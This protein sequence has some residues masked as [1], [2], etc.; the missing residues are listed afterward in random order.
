MIAVHDAGGVLLPG[1]EAAA[2][3]SLGYSGEH[4]DAK[5][6]Q[7]YLRAR[8][9]DP[10]N[11]RFNRL[12]PFAGNMQDPQSLHK[13]A[14]VHGDPIMSVDP[15]GKYTAVFLALDF[16]SV[17]LEGVYAGYT[18]HNNGSDGLEGYK[19]GV[20][21]S[22]L[23]TVVLTTV[24][25]AYAPG[26][27]QI[28][29][30]LRVNSGFWARLFRS[31]EFRSR[32]FKIAGHRPARMTGAS[33]PGRGHIPP[34]VDLN[35]LDTQVRHR[36]NDL[37]VAPHEIHDRAF[38]ADI[39]WSSGGAAY[40]GKIEVDSGIFRDDLFDVLGKESSEAWRQL[41]VEERIDAV[42]IHESIE[43]R[44]VKQEA[45]SADA[46]L[47]PDE[48]QSSHLQTLVQQVQKSHE[49]PVSIN[50]RDFLHKQLQDTFGI[51]GR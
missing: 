41:S 22:A 14:Y 50:V 27:A 1:G 8:F 34:S 18:A 16:I 26:F 35:V 3:T 39:N 2:L 40:E 7:Q 49:L 43:N 28:V 46:L 44:I 11:G 13:Y 51:I 21:M 38:N 9:Y 10:A 4:F 29:R 24:F 5:A 25:A 31:P 6:Q 23:T 30:H 15:T 33:M 17:H 36:M 45:R 48:W 37:G 42:I 47:Y 12:D 32:A 19:F 20:Q